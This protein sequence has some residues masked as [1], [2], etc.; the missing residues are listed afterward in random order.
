MKSALFT[1]LYAKFK[2]MW[3]RPFLKFALKT[4]SIYMKTNASCDTENF[5]TSTQ[6]IV[7]ENYTEFLKR[8]WKE[9]FL[10]DFGP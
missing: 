10:T 7:Q 1:Q 4:A 5:L 9:C 6:S 3:K 2:R 8:L